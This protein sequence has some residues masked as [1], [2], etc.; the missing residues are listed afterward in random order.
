MFLCVQT[1]QSRFA[2]IRDP[3]EHNGQL[4]PVG[5]NPVAAA[6]GPGLATSPNPHGGLARGALYLGAVLSSCLAP[7]A[8][9][10]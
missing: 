7:G 2:I 3:I 10:T 4:V 9:M 5:G 8:R 6:R 1:G